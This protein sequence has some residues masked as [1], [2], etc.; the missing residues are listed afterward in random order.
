MAERI[1][2][3][4][5]ENPRIA[6]VIPVYNHRRTLRQVVEGAL[7]HNPLV[8]VV[9]DGSTDGGPTTLRGLPVRLVRLDG[10]QGKGAALRA[11]AQAAAA[12][13]ASHMIT[14]DADGQHYTDDIPLFIA[15]VR[16]APHAVIVG[17]RNFNISNVPFVSRFGRAFSTFWMLVQT[18]LTVRDMQSGYRAYP[19]QVLE[20]LKLDEKG[21]AFE[22][23]A[24]V[25][26]A[27]AGFHIR[28]IAVRVHY[29]DPVERVSHFH[30]LKDNLRLSLLNTRLTLRALAP[31]PFCQH[32]V[33][34]DGRI[35]LLRPMASLRRLLADRAS[36]HELAR[37]AGISMT[38]SALPLPGLQSILLLLAIGRL[39]L[40]RICALSVVPLAWPPLVP[41]LGVL[42]GYRLRN[43][44]WLTEFSL[45]TLGYEAPQRLLDWIAGGMCLAPLLGGAV[46]AIV[47]VLTA[48]AIRQRRP[49]NG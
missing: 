28:E 18:G 13:G 46:W 29:P 31:V 1:D 37:A 43:G 45:Q 32:T 23:E 11:G 44:S 49:T 38:I 12:A 25:R 3:V 9:D 48:L 27:W 47:F 17:R 40:N 22:I 6:V 4:P 41:G 26:A 2:P 14:L 35:S 21:Y 8:L 30:P 33:N 5:I 24:L 15:A 39:G 36:P 7:R 19:L 10:N 16:E 20:S 42:L 34:A